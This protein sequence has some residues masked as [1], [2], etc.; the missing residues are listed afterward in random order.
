MA[1]QLPII[2]GTHAVNANVTPST[3]L[4][5]RGLAAIQSRNLAVPT[6]LNEADLL[7]V[8]CRIMDVAFRM[9]YLTFKQNAKY[10]LNMIREEFGD[11]A[12]NSITIDHLQGAYIGMKKG[13]TSQKEVVNIES[14]DEL[15][16]DEEILNAGI[17]VGGYYI[18]GGFKKFDEYTQAMIK[19]LGE[20]IR[21]YLRLIYESVRYYPDFDSSGMDDA[22]SI[23]SAM[24]TAANDSKIGGQRE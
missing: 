17:V 8:L 7:P 1:D 9:G 13:T 15:Y 23:E 20:N 2:A 3:S 21:P 12:T 14:I 22:A 4:L 16:L 10:V 11:T 19:D 18:E 5:G 6:K 24:M